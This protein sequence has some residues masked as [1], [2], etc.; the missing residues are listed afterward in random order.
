M[1][2]CSVTESPKLLPCPFCGGRQDG[3]EIEHRLDC[4][5]AQTHPRTLRQWTPET[6]AQR[7]AERLERMRER[8]ADGGK[9]VTMGDAEAASKSVMDALERARKEEG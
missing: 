5:L 1:G 2:W 8:E 7:H 3:D 4:Y 9:P 6:Q